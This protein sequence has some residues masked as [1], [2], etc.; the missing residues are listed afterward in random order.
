ME[1]IGYPNYP[2]IRD[3]GGT[4]VDLLRYPDEKEP[5]WGA[6]NPSI[7]F[8]GK[9]VYATT[10]RSSNYVITP[11]GEYKTTTPGGFRNRVYF[12]ELDRDLKLKKLRRVDFDG[13]E[14]VFNRVP[15]DAKLFYRDGWYFTCVVMEKPDIPAARMGVAKLNTRTNKVTDFTLFPGQ[16]PDRPEKNWMLPY[17]PTY[18]FDWVYGANR[19]LVGNTL[20]TWMTDN[21]TVN[22]L[23]GNSNLIQDPE[24]E[25]GYLGVM[26]RTLTIDTNPYV[27]TTFGTRR[28]QRRNYVHY[29]VRFDKQGYITELSDGFQ[30]YKPGVEF[31][32]GLVFR[33]KDALISF[34]R[35]D[36]SS[37]IASLPIDTVLKS[38]KPVEY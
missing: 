35:N 14:I 13:L 33:G 20:N 24:D 3:M 5:Q 21:P 38:L 37:H 15:E 25:E 11:E 4:I 22:Q 12:S 28:I 9:S 18:R 29:F 1:N 19:V 34:G 17:E 16:Q 36:V 27:G 2:F 31:A 6:T 23:R 7:G 30:F 32:A 10:I 26:H 8:N